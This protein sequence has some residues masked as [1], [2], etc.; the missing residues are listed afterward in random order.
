MSFVCQMHTLP[1]SCAPNVYAR[2]L[3][4]ETLESQSSLKVY[5]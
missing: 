4:I 1:M 3:N 2:I 5:F